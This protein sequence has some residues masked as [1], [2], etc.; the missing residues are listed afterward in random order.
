MKTG[1]LAFF[2]LGPAF[3]SPVPAERE[4]WRVG[5]LTLG[6]PGSPI[7]EMQE[8]QEAEIKRLRAIDPDD[9]TAAFLERYPGGTNGDHC[10]W[11]PGQPGKSIDAAG[12]A[13]WSVNA[14]FDPTCT[15][16]GGA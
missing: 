3:A 5:G 10:W 6:K 15:A 4:T 13:H 12:N 14:G 9:P 8:A 2:L 16:F 1:I 7:S 11:V